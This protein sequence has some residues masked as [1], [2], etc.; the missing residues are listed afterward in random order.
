MVNSNRLVNS[1]KNC[2]V[3]NREQWD[4]TLIDLFAKSV[5]SSCSSIYPMDDTAH[6]GDASL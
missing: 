1:C 2:N 3:V 6:K 5:Y 4:S